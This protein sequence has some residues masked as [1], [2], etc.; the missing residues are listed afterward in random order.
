MSVYYVYTRLVMI[1]F[2]VINIIVVVITHA[3]SLLSRPVPLQDVTLVSVAL[4]LQKC[5]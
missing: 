1:D 4:F 3:G 5:S 2:I